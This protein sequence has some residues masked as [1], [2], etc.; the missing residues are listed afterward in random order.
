MGTMYYRPPCKGIRSVLFLSPSPRYK[1]LTLE[2]L[3]TPY[4]ALLD[5]SEALQTTSVTLLGLLKAR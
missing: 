4:E 2:A 5:A 3:L 1:K